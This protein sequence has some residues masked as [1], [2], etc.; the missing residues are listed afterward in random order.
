MSCVNITLSVLSD[1][2]DVYCSNATE[3]VSI[4]ASPIITDAVEVTAEQVSVAADIKAFNAVTPLNFSVSK[5]C[6]LAELIS[7]I[8]NGMWVNAQPWVNTEGW[9]N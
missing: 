7:C 2:A 9:K 1:S 6:S 5:V 3:D 4:F 8:G